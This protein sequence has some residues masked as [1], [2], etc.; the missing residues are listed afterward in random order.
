M[1]YF[2]IVGSIVLAGLLFFRILSCNETDNLDNFTDDNAAGD[3]YTSWQWKKV[4]VD[5]SGGAF[6]FVWYG[7]TGPAR[8]EGWLQFLAASPAYNSSEAAVPN[9]ESNKDLQSITNPD[10]SRRADA[11]A[12]FRQFIETRVHKGS[13][14]YSLFS[15]IKEFLYEANEYI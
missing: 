10:P 7:S 5:A 14:I 1:R 3:Y 8:N 6:G 12:N 15:P 11:T 2:R 13:G 9:E 4:I